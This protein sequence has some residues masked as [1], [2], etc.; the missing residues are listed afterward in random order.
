MERQLGHNEAKATP[1]KKLRMRLHLRT[2]MILVAVLTL[3]SYL[4]V[5]PICRYYAL[6]PADRAIVDTLERRVDM[7]FGNGATL[8]DVLKHIIVSSR[9]PKPKGVALPPGVPIYVEPIALDAAH[10]TMQKSVHISSKGAKLR[11][12]LVQVLQPLGLDYQVKDGLLVITSEKAVK[13]QQDDQAKQ[14][15]G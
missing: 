3:L 14:P 9:P 12:S 13:L 5:L 15:G 2:M 11:T 6:S 7:P 8:S 10:V 1:M 4:F